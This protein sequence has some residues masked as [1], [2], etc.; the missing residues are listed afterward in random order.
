M[1]G[2]STVAAI[3]VSGSAIKADCEWV[4]TSSEKWEYAAP[5]GALIQVTSIKNRLR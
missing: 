4:P 2:L 3:E 1:M 5:N